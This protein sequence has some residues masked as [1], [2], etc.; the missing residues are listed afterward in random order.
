MSNKCKNKAK[1]AGQIE[2][3]TCTKCGKEHPK[4]EC[5]AKNKMCDL[6]R[7]IGH[8]RRV[9]RF[10]NGVAPIFEIGGLEFADG[11]RPECR[12]KSKVFFWAK[13]GKWKPIQC[14]LSTGSQVSVLTIRHLFDLGYSRD[15]IR[16]PGAK[17]KEIRD[18]IDAIG[19]IDL[20]LEYNNNRVE[21]NFDIF[22]D[23]GNGKIP[24]LGLHDMTAMNIVVMKNGKRHII[25]IQ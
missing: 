14:V 18:P 1:S 22:E 3:K 20:A 17:S 16:K 5:P 25:F 2:I 24:M 23:R 4:D 11:T 19:K 8:F 10:E 13:S 21:V 9:C 15:D 7:D 6:C 12:I